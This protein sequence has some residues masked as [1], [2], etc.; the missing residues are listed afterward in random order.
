M[1]FRRL[2]FLL[3]AT[4][5]LSL[6]ACGDNKTHVFE[7]AM[8]D[9]GDID[10]PVDAPPDTLM[11]GAT[12]NMNCGGTCTNTNTDNNNCGA[13]GTVCDTGA[14]QSC[15]SGKCCGA[16][17]TNC[18][19]TCVNVNTS[20]A[21]CGACAGT[22]GGDVC[23]TTAGETCQNGTCCGG[24]NTAC[25]NQCFDLQTS[26]AHCGN[27]QTSCTTGV[28]E[29]SSGKCCP[30]GQVNCNNVC[31]DV[32]S[33]EANCGACA[34]TTG[35]DVCDTG[36]GETC[37]DGI[38]CGT[39]KINCG[40]VCVD[41]ETD[42]ANCGACAGTSGADVCDTGAGETCTNGVCC[43]A[44]N[45]SCNGTSCTNPQ[46]DPNNCGGCG[47]DV[48]GTNETCMSGLCCGPGQL[49]CGG[50]CV[51]PLSDAANCGGCAG[52]GGTA[53]T[54]GQVCT[55]GSC[56]GS[57]AANET[58]CP[59][60]DCANFLTDHEHCGSCTNACGPTEVCNNGTCT[61]S[62]TVGTNCSGDCVDLSSD[63]SHCGNCTNNC[64]SGQTCS[65]GICCDIGKVYTNGICCQ[66][67]EINCNGQCR[68]PNSDQ[69]CGGCNNNCTALNPV[70]ECVPDE[71]GTTG[72]R[73]CPVGQVNCNG[74]C[75]DLEV[76]GAG[77]TNCGQCGITC[78]TG[79]GQTCD[80]G[81]CCDSN[82]TNCPVTGG[83]ETCTDVSADN[84][85]CG[86]C[87]N[88]CDSGTACSNG[89]CCPALQYN[90]G[91]AQAP[92]CCDSNEI[93]CNVSGTLTCINPATST[94][95]CGGCAG[96]GGIA[97]GT[98]QFCNAGQC[99]N[100]CTGT[101]FN[102]LCGF[103]TN[104]SEDEN[105]C[106]TPGTNTPSC[107][108]CPAGG[109]CV[110][111]TCT[112]P[113]TNPLECL[114]TGGGGATSCV[115]PGGV[116]TGTAGGNSANC[117]GCGMT[118]ACAAGQQC[119][120]SL[121]PIAA[122]PTGATRVGTTATF[123]TTRNHGLIAGQ[124]VFVTNVANTAYNSPATG[125]VVLASGLTATQFQV[126]LATTPTGNSGGGTVG[127]GECCGAG[128]SAC[129][130]TCIDYQTD[131]ANCGGCG[132][133]CGTDQL[134]VGGTCECGFNQ[135]RCGNA[136]VTPSVDPTHCGG[137]LNGEVPSE[138]PGGVA[139]NS[140]NPYCVSG[141]CISQCPAPLTGC[142]ASG[143][144]VAGC[145]NLD[146]DDNNCG[147]CG[148]KCSLLGANFGCS[149][150]QCVQRLIPVQNPPRCDGGGPPIIVDD[151]T[152]TE[153]TGNIGAT[154]FRFALC[155][156]VGLPS[157][158]GVT[159]QTMG[160]GPLSRDVITDAFDSTSGPYVAGAAIYG[161]GVG[162][163]ASTQ[164]SAV[165]NVGGD[166]WV[167]GSIGMATKGVVDVKQRMY[168]RRSFDYSK[169][170]LV[171][172][173][174]LSGTAA[175][176]NIVQSLTGLFAGDP[177]G[178][179]TFTGAAGN[180]SMTVTGT[181]ATAVACNNLPSSLS[182]STD[183]APITNGCGLTTHT[184]PNGTFP[185][186][187]AMGPPCDT[188]A[189]RIDVIGIV[190]HAK[191]DNDNDLIVDAN[192]QPA[193]LSYQALNNSTAALT[194]L[195]LPCG[196]YYFDTI[197]IGK[198]TTIVVH[199]RTAIFVGGS[200]RISQELIFDLDPGASLDIF[201]AG[202][203][204]VSN[205]VTLGSPAYPRLTRLYIG[206]ASC[207]GT[208]SCSAD[209]A[210]C[211]GVCSNGTCTSGGGNLSQ[212]MS[213]SQGGH[214]NG[215][216]WAGYGTFTHSNPLEM[217]G[218]IYANYFDA[219]GDTIIHYDKGAILTG[220]ECPPPP[221]GQT[222]ESC[223][224]CGNQAC[225]NNVC[226]SCTNDSQCCPPLHCDAGTCKL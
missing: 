49:A 104:T 77:E 9:T 151:G 64:G 193:P 51:D 38:C 220:E 91:T 117:G 211:S 146:S 139:C 180:T 95:N 66:L 156:L 16:G 1:G 29:C 167:Y 74:T 28:Q 39:G 85:N 32:N 191:L 207:L 62:C 115:D 35:S 125:W 134:C 162:T 103:C 92:L 7:D 86:T 159:S 218:S 79:A 145:R 152:Q 209:S 140:A 172:G 149:A 171:R 221:S 129:A 222:C 80:D 36:A 160:I 33:D 53:C 196:K 179:Q 206:S 24:S 124:T 4:F 15:T 184:T 155:T 30:I 198:T 137:C 6:A 57:C 119:T 147:A 102:T 176:A 116:P 224:Q 200:V 63:P 110:S 17:E 97:C 153:C 169:D 132:N 87:G 3:S 219:S 26:E 144:S 2:T 178:T 52:N 82:E 42:E 215:L 214:F 226:G 142:P 157:P 37:S 105:A 76:G 71:S 195:D 122:S 123:T 99:S 31:V 223:L 189:D 208:G 93:A 18:G 96:V 163:N 133:A 61:G 130:G 141:G 73:C 150:G 190:E 8:I 201:V 88:D 46:I 182:V 118:W 197:Q 225:I 67:G 109:T 56:S 192:G 185:G 126:T 72:V 75:V 136:C 128:L 34:G 43:A 173:L 50:Q 170:V 113:T 55:S 90:A 158:T 165:T 203:V 131:E 89:Y 186:A 10:A 177:V 212:A 68:D 84:L 175:T 54:T 60:G 48:C 40:D 22:T 25:G 59:G 210:C 12:P 138:D 83:G 41:P 168:V 187:F 107:D 217:Y 164:S 94:T 70:N 181:L 199:G 19:G 98:G 27:C 154:S 202:V 143:Q 120:D 81:L 204:N 108:V 166:F 183:P 21:H 194:R 101:G 161:G 78:N 44:G 205:D 216:I 5:V 69:F 47:V 13:C 127:S 65:S 148:N 121:T 114:I 213:L 20:N 45:V 135:V 58:Q 112:C 188:T 106:G 14:G 23:D 111:G 11:C 100:Q 174:A